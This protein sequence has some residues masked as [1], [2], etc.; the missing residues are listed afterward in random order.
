MV[1]ASRSQT[2]VPETAGRGP[3]GRRQPEPD[4]PVAGVAPGAAAQAD[5]VAAVVVPPAV[6]QVG[7][8]ERRE[9]LATRA[10]EAPGPSGGGNRP[11]ARTGATR[12]AQRRSAGGIWRRRGGHERP[13]DPLRAVVGVAHRGHVDAVGDH[14]VP[15]VG[16]LRGD[17][18]A[19]GGGG[20]RVELAAEHQHR[21]VGVAAGRRHRRR[22]RVARGRRGPPRAPVEH[23]PV[24]V[25][26]LVH[27]ERPEGAGVRGRAGVERGGVLLLPDRRRRGHVVELRVVVAGDRGVE[28]LAVG[29]HRPGVGAAA[30]RLGD[31]PQQRRAVAGQPGAQRGGELAVE[32]RRV[33]RPEGDRRPAPDRR[34][35]P[36][37]CGRPRR[38]PCR[39]TASPAPSPAPSR[40]SAG[41]AVPGPPAG[42][43]PLAD[44]V[45]R[46]PHRRPLGRVPRVSP[47]AG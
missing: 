10:A 7:D 35:P 19:L 21:Y 39:A 47:Y 23:L 17:Q 4:H 34:R 44:D 45:E 40:A 32:R 5:A 1:P 28:A 25:G 12:P 29:P 18:V 30:G 33:R 24:G 8:G 27:G 22:G 2:A 38:T 16:E 36:A 20:D 6:L 13:H 43:R 14:H 9:P 31:Q 37:S 11:S 42:G 15:R 3:G 46:A 41:T 26:V